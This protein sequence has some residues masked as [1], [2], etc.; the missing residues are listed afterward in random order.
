MNHQNKLRRM[1]RQ[2]TQWEAGSSWKQV[3][4]WDFIYTS[5]VHVQNGRNLAWCIAFHPMRFEASL[6]CMIACHHDSDWLVNYA[7][8]REAVAECMTWPA[9]VDSPLDGNIGFVIITTVTIIIIIDNDN[10]HFMYIIEQS[11][12]ANSGFSAWSIANL[13][14]ICRDLNILETSISTV[15]QHSFSNKSLVFTVSYAAR[16]TNLKRAV[17]LT[18]KHKC[19]NWREKSFWTAGTTWFSQFLATGAGKNVKDEYCY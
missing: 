10:E 8:Y 3:D 17:Q 7:D 1:T 15:L 5:C 14:F 2:W 19:M 11:L 12:L 6:S 4:I 18:G 16:S 9:L 13:Q